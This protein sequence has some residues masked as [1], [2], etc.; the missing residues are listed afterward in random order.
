VNLYVPNDGNAAGD[1]AYIA[2]N[3]F[4][5]NI[6]APDDTVSPDPPG[7]FPRLVSWPDQTTS[8]PTTSVIRIENNFIDPAILDTSLGVNHPGGIFAPAWGFGNVQGNPL[9]TNKATR[10]F[11]L[12]PGS[13]AKGSAPGGLDF[14]ATV[15]EWAYILNVPPAQTPSTSAN[16]IIGGPGVV[17]YKWRLDGGA[18]SAPIQIGSGGVMPRTGPIVRQATLA[19]SSLANGPHTLEVLGQDMAGNWQDS[20]PARTL[21]ATPQ[22]G[23]TTVTWTVNSALQ[24]IRLNEV[25][26]ASGT[27]PDTIEL[28]NGGASDVN[29][30]GWSLSDDPLAV[31]QYTI[32]ANTIIP[33][34]GYATFQTTVTG[35]N[36]DDEGDTIFLRN[37]AV[38][39]DSISFGH[40]IPDFTIG[41][42]GPAAVWTLCTPTFGA[43]NVAARLGDPNAV[44]I[45][46]WFSSG[47]VLYDN[48]WI[49][50]ANP[51]A[52]P[53]DLSGLLLTD[54]PAGAPALHT[55][56]PLSFIAG[57]GFVKFIAD[58]KPELAPTHLGFALDSE[59]EQ[60]ALFNGNTQLDIVSFY[61]QTTDYSMGRDPTSPTGYAF[62][63]LPTAG[64]ANGTSDPR[65]PNALALLRGLR[66]TEI[67]FNPTGGAEFEFVE[68]RNV[69]ATPLELGGVK[70]V[71]GIDF[72][73]PAMTLNPGDDVV[74]VA[75]LAQFQSRYG[76]AV[77]IGGV[78]A[79]R[80]DNSGEKL[81]IQLPPPFDA[82]VLT[83]NYQDY[84][85]PSTD[86]VGRSL[87]VPNPLV[88]ANQWSDRDT[89]LASARDG[90]DPDGVIATPQ[91]YIPWAAF[92]NVPSVASD[93]DQDGVAALVE[94]T[95]GMNPTT[96]VGADGARGLPTTT[97]GTDGRLSLHMLIPENMSAVQLHGRPEITYTVQASDDLATWTTVATKTPTTP[98]TGPGTVTVGSSVNG[99]VPV[100][101]RDVGSVSSRR[102]MHLQLI[103]SP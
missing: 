84:W 23:P 78:F 75:N 5:G 77:N 91:T 18:W 43:V 25:L 79:G 97:L 58:G 7:G 82:N 88:P 71:E 57:N 35:I 86:G 100:T 3:I 21:E 20:D 12:Q 28:Y 14:G 6:P 55:I 103:Y 98:W 44:R 11:S 37:G 40:Q 29:V 26:A 1:G 70:F 10:D 27:L 41:R 16:L 92:F 90:G 95:L 66:I 68:L 65:Y 72:V 15:A 22:F 49:E 46:E 4:F 73:F 74:L 53:V 39:V 94:F 24:L 99:L 101:V 54:N 62:Y 80:L 69:G 33:A 96:G 102:Y 47:D 60:I 87:V 8:G 50:L 19:L 63:V 89:W 2:Y 36:I 59:Q 31:A 61:P 83:F 67:M 52:L 56:A 93:N 17:A 51:G 42:I 48:D 64:L 85:F 13:P 38:L 9:F 45:N 76:T 34:G 32:P 30:G 81:A